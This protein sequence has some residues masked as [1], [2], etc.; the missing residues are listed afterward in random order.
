MSASLRRDIGPATGKGF[1]GEISLSSVLALCRRHLAVTIIW[2][3]LWTT[4]AAIA[5]F[6]LIP[7]YEAVAVVVLD[8]RVQRPSDYA[9][10]MSGPFTLTES[11]PIVRSE[12]QVLQSPTLAGRVIDE[13][14]LADTEDFQPGHG[15]RARLTALL[16]NAITPFL[17]TDLVNALQP[18]VMDAE[19]QRNLMIKEYLGRLSV[20]NDGRSL[21]ISVM[22]WAADPK[23]AAQIVNAHIRLY[24][25]DQSALKE[26]TSRH[27]EGWIGEQVERLGADLHAKEDA[28]RDFRERAGLVNAQGFTIISQRVS[29]INEELSRARAELAQREALFAQVQYANAS[30][31]EVPADVLNS[32]LIQKL[33]QQEAELTSALVKMRA[34]Y[35][36]NSAS[37]RPLKAQ[38]ADV[39]EKITEETARIVSSM[40]I[41]ADV[42]RQRVDSLTTRLSAAEQQLVGEDR[43]D[44]RLKEMER[45]IEAQRGVYRD[46]MSRQQQIEAETGAEQADARIVSL[47]STPYR[48]FY[49]NKP[50]FLVLGFIA[51]STSGIGLAFLLDCMCKGVDRLDEIPGAGQIMHFHPISRVRPSQ[52]GRRTL[53][54]HLLNEPMGEFADGIRSLRGDIIHS[55]QSTTPRV[56]VVTSALPGEGKTTI[57]LSIARSMAAAGANVLLID[58]D[59][60]RSRCAE[61]SGTKAAK[62]GL[63][64]LLNG[65]TTF[66]AALIADPGSSAKILVA[67]EP[68]A[69]PQDLLEEAKLRPVLEQAKAQFDFVIIDT[70]PLAAVNDAWLIFPRADAV[71]LAVRWRSTSAALV[72]ETISAFRH[73]NVPLAGLFLNS[74]DMARSA[75]DSG[76]S[77]VYKA[78]KAYYPTA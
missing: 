66:G 33:R 24:I 58:C 52:L 35:A 23:L 70:P 17:P 16:R 73:R 27:A 40:Q 2:T 60:R 42:A 36:E 6:N 18:A 63:V 29:Q 8:S 71:V 57:S 50:L 13:L 59:L 77:D 39:R 3:V 20:E 54:D 56:L 15:M 67:E 31:F 53:A 75:R 12:T 5:I 28:L 43:S 69:M 38:V 62:N 74:V 45:D 32:N 4:V 30:H 14:H 78:I 48:P 26:A 64:G 51:S 7:E 44:T 41:E 1:S 11:A 76:R 61:M 10:V 22:F 68:V 34:S 49:P 9:S 19:A 21:T 55:G 72:S 37:V 47:A 46:L 25:A 65:S